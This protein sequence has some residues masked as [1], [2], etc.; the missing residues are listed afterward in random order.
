[1]YAPGS[2]TGL[3]KCLLSIYIQ[4]LEQQKLHNSKVI[5]FVVC[6]MLQKYVN[7]L[8]GKCLLMLGQIQKYCGAMYFQSVF[9]YQ[10]QPP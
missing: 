6:G 4:W 2:C 1:M 8:E 5:H 10:H 7:N 9:T 3:G